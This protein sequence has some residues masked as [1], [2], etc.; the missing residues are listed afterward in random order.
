MKVKSF[1]G[2][3]FPARH[4]W[5]MLLC[6]LNAFSGKAQDEIEIL[7]ADLYGYEKDGEKFQQLTNHVEVRQDNVYLYCDSALKNDTRNVIDAYGNVRLVQGDSL[8]VTGNYLHYDGNTRMA[9]IRKK[10]VLTQP[11]FTLYTEELDYDTRSKVGYYPVPGRIINKENTLTSESGYYYPNENVSYF[12]KNVKL[13][14][15]DYIIRCDTLKY[16]NAT[17]VAYFLGATS[18]RKIADSTTIT[19][20]YGWYDKQNGN[21]QFSRCVRVVSP[22]QTLDCDSLTWDNQEERGNA[23]RDILVIDSTNKLTVQGEFGFYDRKKQQTM[24]TRRA[25]ATK[26][27]DKDTMLMHGDT[28]YY[29]ADTVPGKKLLSYR[30][31]RIFKNDMQAVCDSFAYTFKDSV[32]RFFSHPV[33]WL[34]STQLTADSIYISFRN[35]KPDELHMRRNSFIASKETSTWFNQIKGRDVNGFFKDDELRLV[36]V[37]KDGECVYFVKDDSSAFI[38]VNKIKCDRMD[39]LLEEGKVSSVNYIGQPDGIVYPV[40]ELTPAE[41]LLKGFN[42]LEKRHP[43]KKTDLL[44]IKL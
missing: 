4:V 9:G 10:V 43:K 35:N 3:Y 24:V 26:V 31:V 25:L 38:G 30:D 32:M 20:E 39:I 6:L 11:G 13:V 17:S 2:K 12:K 23:Y 7:H 14:N 28:L 16:N 15:K 22:G 33:I 8:T 1:F 37:L 29:Y 27:S 18:I 34:D 36:K 44:T 19:C 5:V 41:L 40:S 21:S 42:W